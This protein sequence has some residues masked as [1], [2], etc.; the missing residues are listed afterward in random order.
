MRSV[1]SEPVRRR[2]WC[3]ALRVGGCFNKSGSVAGVS[4]RRIGVVRHMYKERMPT[5]TELAPT[6]DDPAN[7]I[8]RAPAI[9]TARPA[10]DAEAA[11]EALARG[12][13]PGPP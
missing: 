11:H 4:R 2:R 5:F 1:E 7:T 3:R 10:R 8:H 13:Q 12:V 9:A 6:N